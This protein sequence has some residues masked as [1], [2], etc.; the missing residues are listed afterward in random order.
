MISSLRIEINILKM[1]F[2]AKHGILYL[3]LDV[4]VIDWLAFLLLF[5]QLSRLSES[6]FL[7]LSIFS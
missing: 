2:R 6:L 7:F 4:C 3:D 1:L 5:L